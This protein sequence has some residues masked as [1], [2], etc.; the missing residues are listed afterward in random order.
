MANHSG[1]V[2]ESQA[3]YLT[4]S[5]HGDQAA[6]RMLDLAYHLAREEKDRGNRERP[7]RMM[8]YEGTHVGRVDYGQRDSAATILRLSGDAAAEHF[9]KAFDL[10]DQVTRLDLAVTWHARPS[11]PH[12]GANAYSLA[13]MHY[14]EDHTR[15]KPWCVRDAAGGF[16]CYVGARGSEAMLRLYNKGAEEIAAG[17]PPHER[18]YQ[19]CW[20]YELETKGTIAKGYAG[21]LREHTARQS[22]VQRVLYAYCE[23]HGIEPAFPSIGASRLIPGLKRR[24]DAESKLRHLAKNVRPTVEWLTEAGREEDVRR[25][26]GLD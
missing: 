11:D 16:T 23:E 13:E 4:V 2:M 14:Q 7:W 17:D 3:D 10:S 8:G 25:V 1:F 24:S 26:L 22:Y 12:I 20:R 15:A 9:D 21:V 6:T 5:A 18:R 19:G